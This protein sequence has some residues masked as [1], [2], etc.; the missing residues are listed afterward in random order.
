MLVSALLSRVADVM[1]DPGHVRWPQAEVLRYASDGQ[2]LIAAHKP[3]AL[4]TELPMTAVA[5]A[6]QT[7]PA[8]AESLLDVRGATLIARETLDRFAPAW[9][10]DTAGPIAHY[11]HDL[12]NPRQFLVYPPAVAGATLTLV[13]V[14]APDDLT[15]TTDSLAVRDPY[16]PA[17]TDYIAFRCYVKDSDDTLNQQRAAFHLELV[18]Q[19]LGVKLEM[20]RVFG[21]KANSAPRDGLK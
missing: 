8:G 3:D 11:M 4:G 1:L 19:A 18:G 17:L 2:R 12:R 21:P 6:K 16:V 5:G 7:L 10:S 9:E 20:S 13:C 14:A 15:E